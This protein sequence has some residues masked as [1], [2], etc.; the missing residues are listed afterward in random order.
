MEEVSGVSDLDESSNYR[1]NFAIG[2][3]G[4]ELAKVEIETK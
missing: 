1:L 2:L 4:T 3:D